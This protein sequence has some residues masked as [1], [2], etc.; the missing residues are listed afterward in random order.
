M[1]STVLEIAL[2]ALL[3]PIMMLIQSG[4]VFQIVT[5]K[6]SGWNPQRRDDGS[7]AFGAIVVRHRWH[8][9]FGLVA[10]IFAY[11]ISPYLFGWMSPTIL[12]LLL[13][14][15]LSWASGQ[16]GIGLWLKRRGLLM[17]PEETAP[18]PIATRAN[19]LAVE[20]AADAAYA[21]GDALVSIRDDAAFRT[22]HQA[23]LPP[24]PRSE[25]G[26]F[27]PDRVMALA[28]IGE[29]ASLDEARRWLT[30]K[31]RFL[32]LHDPAMIGLIARLDDT[33]RRAEG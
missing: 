11:T 27:E 6:D 26:R 15:P 18:P 23:M 21:S 28:K 30:A 24:G 5:G 7:I 3:A 1:I 13:S 2:S 17:T 19:A 14:I 31:E 12:G 9:L 29:A 10:G 16:L 32:A 4:S 33:T 8:T 25:R 22:L 20:L